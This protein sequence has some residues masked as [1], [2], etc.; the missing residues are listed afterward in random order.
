MDYLDDAAARSDATIPQK[1]DDFLDAIQSMIMSFLVKLGPFAVALMPSLFTAYAIFYTFADEAGPILAL[2][3]AI[4]VGLAM[5]TVGIVATHTAIDLYNAKESGVIQPVKFRLMVWLVPVYVVGV[6]S[7]V[8]FSEHAFTPLVKGLGVASPFLT[9][10]VYIAVALARDIRRTE[11][12][13]ERV[14]DKQDDREDDER[15]WQREKERIE[16]ELKHQE[17]MAR[18]ASKQRPNTVQ[19]PSNLDAQ[20]RPLDA[21]NEARLASKEAKLD[22]LLDFLTNNPFASYAD[23]GRQIGLSKSSGEN[24]ARSLMDAG[25]LRR[26]GEGWEVIK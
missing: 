13:Q 26:N 19:V 21:A 5:E 23:I 24:Y 10:I 20:D 17:K 9:C 25:K 14:E 8:Y 22:A 7:V 6:S 15:R 3:F 2:I 4:T 1:F 16:I 12:Q 18:I 11:A